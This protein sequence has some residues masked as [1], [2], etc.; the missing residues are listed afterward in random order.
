MKEFFRKFNQIRNSKIPKLKMESILD[1]VHK[2]LNPAIWNDDMTIKPEVREELLNPIFKDLPERMKDKIVNVHFTGS[3]TGYQ[4]NDSTDIDIHI[5]VADDEVEEAVRLVTAGPQENLA[6]TG[7]RIEYYAHVGDEFV[8]SVGKGSVYDLLNNKWIEKPEYEKIKPPVSHIMEIAKIFMSG[9]DDRIQEYEADKAEI[10]MYQDYLNYAEEWEKDEIET[11]IAQKQEELKSDLDA[12]FLQK[13]MLKDLR[14]GAYAGEELEL[15]GG[16]GKGNKS[17]QNMIYKML[18][19][20]G[21]ILKLKQYKD[22]RRDVE[23]V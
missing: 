21:Y 13:K 10:E 17:I 23:N 16:L 6:D 22:I 2:E 8:G 1:P 14:S 5:E 4:Y 19:K 12:L 18:D 3:N 11:R 7:H 20:T 9:I 15:H